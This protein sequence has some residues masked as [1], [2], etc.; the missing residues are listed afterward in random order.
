MKS[1]SIR[2]AKNGL[3]ELAREVDRGQTIVVTRN[4]RPAFDLVPHQARRRLHR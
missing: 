1:V 4:G 3:T 2:D